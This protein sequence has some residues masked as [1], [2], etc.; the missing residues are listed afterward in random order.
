MPYRQVWTIA[1]AVLVVCGFCIS[2]PDDQPQA[3]LQSLQQAHAALAARVDALT[4]QVADLEARLATPTSLIDRF[5]IERDRW[6]PGDVPPS[7]RAVPF[8]FN[9]MTFYVMPCD[10][11]SRTP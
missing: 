2:A 4:E 10:S 3:G 8:Q 1:I 9:G 5:M 7:R 6:R 11:S